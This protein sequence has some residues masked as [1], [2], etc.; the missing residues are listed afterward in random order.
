MDTNESLKVL[1][2]LCNGNKEEAY[3]L[4]EAVRKQFPNKQILWCVQ[5]AI[6]DR[7]FGKKSS[8][9]LPPPP[10]PNPSLCQPKDRTWGAKGVVISTAATNEKPLA[11]SPQDLQA[12]LEAKRKMAAS[13]PSSEKSRKKLYCLLNGDIEAARRLVH[14]IRIANP[15]C[16]EQWAVDKVIYD[17][18]RDRI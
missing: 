1:L 5:K 6:Y 8:I 14:R 15:E 9:T 13:K 7:R 2:K 16:S 10:P 4:V 11:L 12:L 3:S 18:E 17:L